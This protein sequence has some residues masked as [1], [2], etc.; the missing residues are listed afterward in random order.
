MSADLRL[1]LMFPGDDVSCEGAGLDAW[2]D[3]AEQ[4]GFDHLVFGDH[5][6]GVQPDLMIEGWDQQWPGPPGSKPYT[7]RSVFREPLTLFGYLAARCSLELVTGVLVLPQRQTVLVAKQ[8]AEIDILSR[9]R[10][11]LGVGAGWNSAEF[12][13]LGYD[14][15]RRGRFLD[16]QVEV[17]RRLWT[18]DIVT[19]DGEFHRLPGVG[20]MT[21]PVQ[22]PIPL[23]IGG[24]SRAAVE[25]AGRRGDGWLLTGRSAPNDQLVESIQH[26]RRAAEQAGRDPLSVGIEGR[27]GVGSSWEDDDLR[28]RV[29]DWR[30]VGAT[31]LC[32]DTRYAGRVTID[33][34][35]DAIRHF[36]AV[37][38]RA[39]AAIPRPPRP[40]HPV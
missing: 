20:I 23:W 37:L 3:A 8:A 27:L 31:H 21:L 38:G 7:Y 39:K 36:G 28:Q 9:G 22:R 14:F 40:Q 17:L 4:A 2:V 11:R 19:Y 25:R 13:T 15:S 16:E 12:D 5:V 33:E 34:H 30:R 32:I 35:L 18:Q 6:V 10:L 26:L 24:E 1:G 29:A